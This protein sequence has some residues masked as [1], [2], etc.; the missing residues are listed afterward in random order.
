MAEEES[1]QSERVFRP[2]TG[3]L[4]N[5]TSVFI[6]AILVA[7]M[8][9]M[10]YLRTPK[11]LFPDITI[12]TIYVST[13]YPGNSPVDIENLITRPIEK[14]IDQIDGVNEL[15]STSAQDFSAIVVEF[16]TAQDVEQ[17]LMDVKDAVDR[18]ESE[19]PSDL[20]EEP[21]VQ[22]IDFS[23]FPILNINLSGDFSMN[24]LKNFAEDLED[25]I[26]PLKEISKVEIKG[27]L[28]REIKINVDL[29]A[30]VRNEVTF[31]DIEQAVSNENLNMSGGDIETG[32][33]RRT[34]RIEG[35][36][37]D[38]TKIRDLIVKRK[39]GKVIYLRDI[40][41]VKDG[42]KD[43]DSYARLNGEP[44]VSLDVIKKS[45]EN[46]LAATNKINKKLDNARAA[47]LPERLNVTLTNDQ[48][49]QTRA[50]I[51]NLENS[52][53][54]GVILVVLVLLFFLGGRN[55]WFVGLAIPLSMFLSFLVLSLMGTT[56]NLVVLF[57]LILALGM[58]VDNAI[59]VVEN[60]YRHYNDRG[61]SAYDAA[62]IGTG[63]IAMPIISSTATT[64]AAF[65][66]LLFW[67]DIMGE[68]MY[69]LPFTL[70]VVLTSSLFVALIINPVVARTF[71]QRGAD[72]SRGDDRRS[73]MASSIGLLAALILYLSGL[74]ALGAFVLIVALLILVNHYGLQPL[75]LWFQR[76]FLPFL[77]RIYKAT[78][79]F[80]LRSFNPYLFLVGTFGLL[81]FALVLYFGS[82]PKRELFPV[83]QPKYIN[84][85]AETP[86]GSDIAYTDSIAGVIEKDIERILASDTDIVE[87]IVANVGRGTQ[88]PSGGPESNMGGGSNPNKARITVNF[89]KYEERG[90]KNTRDIMKRMTRELVETPGVRT[91]VKKNQEGPPVGK[92]VNIEVSGREIDTL[93][94]LVQR[95]EQRIKEANIPGIEELKTDV[96]TGKPEYRVNIDREKARRYGVSTGQVGNAL[97]TA[98]F[99]KEVSKYKEGKDDHPIQLRL[100]KEYRN[101]ITDLMNQRITFRD[102]TAGGRIVQVPVST[103]AEAG[104]NTTYGSIKR[105]GLERVITI[106]S[107]VIE[108]YNATRI[109]KRIDQVLARMDL[110]TGYTY[111][112]TGE[113]EEQRE[114]MAFLMQA[115]MI[116]VALITIIL[117]SQFNSIFKPIII[118][119]SVLFSTIGVFLGLAIFD[120]DFIVM[121]TGIG[122]VSLAGIV[123]NNAIVLIDYIDLVR[124]RKKAEKGASLNVRE[125]IEAI[126]EGGNV[127][128]RPVL[129]TA[130][131]TI[132]GLLPLAT[133]MNI[134]FYG[135]LAN[136]DP[137]IYFG[138]DNANFWGPMAW[139]VIFGLAFA[140]FLTL[141]MVP[142]MYLIFDRLQR[143]VSRLIGMR[144]EEEEQPGD[145]V[146]DR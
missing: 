145:V 126:V 112:F 82:D 117:V 40:A 84:V 12:P 76:S 121:M 141:V 104:M 23:E 140:T 37:E 133:A 56:M 71:I 103:V 116:A 11:A 14:E 95:M 138:G 118:I 75:S 105:K 32:R 130:I 131:T 26:E 93:L 8:G 13:P 120:M 39:Q 5:R 61:R 7:V 59:V 31:R 55:A 47:Y 33:S 77:E 73:W 64:L 102:Q 98:L 143:G 62:R 10:G 21:S 68:F 60:I 129:L 29:P 122:I 70:I 119:L 27:T 38:P 52:I 19:L 80:A 81:V 51:S 44:V 35:E 53:I 66:P 6:L 79:R 9:F 114:T 108:G 113:Q 63:E 99:G 30:M 34:V 25:D 139:T 42:Y 125:T 87:S 110:P 49:E 115:M 24:D 85:F 3:A 88:D 67:D 83:N 48:S 74:N 43:R 94:K 89:V 135:L 22:E 17:A 142:V 90:G 28:D 132:L 1:K 136:W 146:D 91:S 144:D 4:R 41:E 134:D 128:L 106:S 111:R 16:G 45:G 78:L 96:E 97:R 72:S 18:A 69:Y 127:R 57:S 107:N 20:K 58:L 50:Q 46:L 109:N 15:S 100:Q 124:A 54:S 137:N 123:V 65:F 36:F 92:P 2:T 86:V 101:D